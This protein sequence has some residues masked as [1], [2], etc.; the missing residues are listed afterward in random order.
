MTNGQRCY[1]S[2]LSTDQ[3]VTGTRQ[4]V[5]HRSTCGSANIG[6]CS[7]VTHY[8]P[9]HFCFYLGQVADVVGVEQELLQAPGIAE[10]VLGHRGQRTVPLIDAL[11]LP[12]AAL[13]YRNA[14]KHGRA[15]LLRR[16]DT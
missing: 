13:E 11:H 3:D 8:D 7:R 6:I 1:L 10:D 12:I 2:L 14:L 4:I 16:H 5:G 9:L 15:G